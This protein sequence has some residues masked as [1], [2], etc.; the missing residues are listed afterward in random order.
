MSEIADPTV[1]GIAAALRALPV[2]P[3][4]EQEVPS[5]LV[6]L[7]ALANGVKRFKRK[8][9]DPEVSDH[10]A[11]LELRRISAAARTIKDVWGNISVT[12][13][14]ARREHTEKNG[15][16]RTE[17]SQ[18]LRDVGCL[19]DEMEASA[20]ALEHRGRPA[21]LGRPR[22]ILAQFFANQA[23]LEVH[24][25][26][27]RDATVIT[28]PITGRAGGPYLRL[29]QALYAAAGIDASAESNARAWVKEKNILPAAD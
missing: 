25:L 13:Y 18:V 21:P 19:A 2:L 14:R 23:A 15:S 1:T 12:G 16:D 6:R 29:L 7:E 22:K 4:C 20:V 5:T 28:D 8:E 3:D 9:L 17:T 27:G 26:T 24:R 10:R 11:A